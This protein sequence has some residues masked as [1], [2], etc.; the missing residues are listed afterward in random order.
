MTEGKA[1]QLAMAAAAGVVELPSR[2]RME[3][4]GKG[5]TGGQA[6]AHPSLDDRNLLPA[7]AVGLEILR[8]TPKEQGDLGEAV[9][10]VIQARQERR[11]PAVG[12]V[13]DL[14]TVTIPALLMPE[15]A[16][17]ALS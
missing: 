14:G 13:V 10:L 7:A 8:A 4:S 9:L 12:V 16:A 15:T 5:V 6:V 1:I 11:T 3:W 17:A 2:G